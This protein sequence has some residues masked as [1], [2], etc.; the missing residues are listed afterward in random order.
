MASIGIVLFILGFDDTGVA[1]VLTIFA[2]QDSFGTA[3]NVTGN[4]ALAL[5]LNGLFKKKVSRE[6]V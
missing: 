6:I 4:G 2:I 3:C 1:L 5:I